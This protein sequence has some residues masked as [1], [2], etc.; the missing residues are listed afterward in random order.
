M[1]ELTMMS[2]LQNDTIDNDSAMVNP[3][4]VSTAHP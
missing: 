3:V 4:S 2:T 1:S